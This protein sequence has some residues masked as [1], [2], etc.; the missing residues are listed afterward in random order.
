MATETV[1]MK[2][3]GLLVALVHRVVLVKAGR[4]SCKV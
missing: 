1:Q 3:L 2:V 4:A